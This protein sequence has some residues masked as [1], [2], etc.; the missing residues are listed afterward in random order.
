[1]AV[2]PDGILFV[3]ERGAD[4]SWRCP[5][6]TRTACRGSVEVGSGYGNAHDIEFDATGRC[7]SPA[8]AHALPSCTSTGCTTARS[9]EVVVDGLPTGGHSTKTVEV[10]PSGDLLLSI[11]SSCDVCSEEDPRRASVQLLTP[12]DELR[13]YMRGLRNAVGAVG[14]RRD[15]AS[16]GDE[17]GPRSARRRSAAGDGLRAHRRRRCRLAALPRRRRSAIPSSAPAPMPATAWR[18]PPPPSRRTRR[19]SPS[20]AGRIT[21]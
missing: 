10:L 17:H 3:A 7:S 2:S 16:V 20:S 15:G 13:P 19:R 14:R 11:G 6:T 1:M 12:M 21:W 4:R 18:C 9:R 5:T 8:N